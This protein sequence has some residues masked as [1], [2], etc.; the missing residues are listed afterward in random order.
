[1]ETPVTPGWDQLT[2]EPESTGS[3][4]FLTGSWDIFQLRWWSQNQV[5]LCLNLNRTSAQRGPN[6]TFNLNMKTWFCGL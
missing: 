3:D 4:L 1:M 5:G 6:V 2:A